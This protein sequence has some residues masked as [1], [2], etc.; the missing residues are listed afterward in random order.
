MVWHDKVVW[1]EGMFLRAQHFQQQDRYVEHL[2]EARA[3]PLRPH[4]WGVTELT[5]DRD[6]LAA[7]RF[8]LSAAT[9]IMED[10]TP[11]SIP[12]GADAPLPLDL[13]E[14]TRNAVVYLAVPLR[15]DGSPEVTASEL[16]ADA[17]RARFGLRSFEAFDTHSDSTMAAELGIGRLRFRYLL[18]TEE[19]AGYS[20]LG[21]ARI[22]EVQAD[23]RVQ[24]DDRFIP[25]C[26]RVSAT[27]VLI[28]SRWPSW[29]ACWDSARRRLRRGWASR[30]PEAWRTWP[31]SCCS[32]PS[33]AGTR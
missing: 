25:P 22:I 33:I 29:S 17:A 3:A 23:R 5:I 24:L 20:C 10:G 15:Q 27:V 30:A 8:A 11:F 1:Q 13:P 32:R 4:P 9:G 7:G 18:E 16:S 6:L 31:I 12:G 2:L 21:L 19:L 14:G 28:E 26:L